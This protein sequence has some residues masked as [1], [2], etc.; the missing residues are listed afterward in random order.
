MNGV[1]YKIT[2]VINGK[3][4][5]G[6]TKNFSTRKTMHLCKLRN[7]K[8]ANA[9]LQASYNK[10]GE[11]SFVF[12]ILETCDIFDLQ[13]LEQMWLDNLFS[14]LDDNEIYNLARYACSPKGTHGKLSEQTK[15]KIRQKHLGKT[16]SEETKQKIRISNL[17][18]PSHRKGA[19]QEVT[20]EQTLKKI[21]SFRKG[22]YYIF[23]DIVTETSYEVI[24]IADFCRT[25]NLPLKTVRRYIKARKGVYKNFSIEYRTKT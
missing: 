9:K 17:G 15:E 3:M 14:S 6:S 24:N 7:N 21:L 11:D 10:H 20:E 25:L 2:N 4:Y 12:E 8:H 16:L 18:K 5:I 13:K 23:K 19:K 1:I 22:D